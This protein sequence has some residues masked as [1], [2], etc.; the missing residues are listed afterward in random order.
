MPHL[1]NIEN[2]PTRL[3]RFIIKIENSAKARVWKILLLIL[4]KEKHKTKFQN[5]LFFKSDEFTVTLH[6][7]LCWT[8]QKVS[9]NVIL[10]NAQQQ[11]CSTFKVHDLSTILIYSN[12]NT[13][14]LNF[15]TSLW[16]KKKI[17]N[18]HL[19]SRLSIS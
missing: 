7:A 18:C 19:V 2:L 6:Y 1:K 9:L 3:R 14:S 4:I 13:L 17:I 12:E 11:K 15:Y 8:N 5:A 16:W 10:R